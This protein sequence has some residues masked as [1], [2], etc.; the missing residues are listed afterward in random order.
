MKESTD[1]LNEN[2]LLD[3]K[4]VQELYFEYAVPFRG[5]VGIFDV[6]THHNLP[7]IIENKPFSN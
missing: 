3:T 4:E 7:Q 1:Y 6:H 2:W 5:K